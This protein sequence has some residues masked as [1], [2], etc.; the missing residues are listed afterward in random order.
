MS[1]RESRQRLAKALE[2]SRSAEKDII[3]ADA[4]KDDEQAARVVDRLQRAQVGSLR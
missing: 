4:R 2:Q 1:S 3:N